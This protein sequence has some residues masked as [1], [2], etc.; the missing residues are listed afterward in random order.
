MRQSGIDGAGFSAVLVV[1]VGTWRY[2]TY[3][4]KS[5]RTTGKNNDRGPHEKAA[6]IAAVLARI[7]NAS[8]KKRVKIML[9]HYG[10][11]PVANSQRPREAYEQ[12]FNN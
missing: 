8:P 12:P 1:A 6:T 9:K 11:D 5:K 3:F 4:K 2:G 7:G 10:R